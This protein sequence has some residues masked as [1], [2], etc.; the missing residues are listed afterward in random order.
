M[1]DQLPSR[2]WIQDRLEHGDIDAAPQILAVLGAVVSGRFVDREA[3]DWEAAGEAAWYVVASEEGH[4]DEGLEW[5]DLVAS[6]SQSF[7]IGVGKAAVAAAI[8]D[9]ADE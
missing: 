3:I 7:W 8:G 5:D 1:S 4:I 2:Q 6:D 9:T